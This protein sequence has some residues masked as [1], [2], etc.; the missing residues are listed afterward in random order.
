MNKKQGISLKQ[1]DYTGKLNEHQEYLSILKRLEKSCIYIEYVLV[2]EDDTRLIERFSSLMISMNEKN[3]WWGTKSS[4]KSKVYRFK[5]SKALFDYL[6]QFETF[7]RYSVSRYGDYAQE[8]DFG[9]NDIAFF[10]HEAI[11][12]LFTT[13]HEGYIIIREDVL[14]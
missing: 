4:G 14:R 2:N 13:T 8:T 12:L 6:K 7:C 3:K 11:P 9:I 1:I 10:D 5:A